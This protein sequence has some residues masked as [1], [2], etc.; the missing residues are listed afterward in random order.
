MVNTDNASKLGQNQPSGTVRMPVWNKLCHDIVQQQRSL[1]F[2]AHLIDLTLSQ[3][4]I[5]LVAIQTIKL[6]ET[7]SP[8][9][10]TPAINRHVT[11]Y[12]IEHK[13]NYPHSIQ[14]Q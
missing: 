6:P 2:Y 9:Q 10:A 12:P 5:N 13:N 3:S 11:G 14:I 8:T 4:S 1:L 7:P